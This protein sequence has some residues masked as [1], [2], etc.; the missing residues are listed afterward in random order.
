MNATIGTDEAARGTVARRRA[1]RCQAAR[2]QAA[3]FQATSG[4]AARGRPGRGPAMRSAGALLT[5]L[6]LLAT[7]ATATMAATTMAATATRPSD[8]GQSAL[9]RARTTPVPLLLHVEAP[10]DSGRHLGDVVTYQA[11]LAWPPGWEI[12]R[13]GIPAPVPDNAPIELSSYSTRAAPDQCPTCRWLDLRWQVFKAV[14]M[15]EDLPLPAPEVRFR[16][17]AEIA[18]V[19]LPPTVVSVSPLVPWERRKDWIDSIRAG[20]GPVFLD[21]SRLWWQAALAAGLGLLALLGWGWA[22]GRWFL[23]R[24]ARP[25]ARAW[26]SVQGRHAADGAADQAQTEDLKDWHR[27]FDATA[28]E[29]VVPGRLDAFLAAHRHLAP[30]ADEIRA[31]FEA[32]QRHFFTEALAPV[33]RLPRATLIATLRRLADAEFRP[34]A[35]IGAP[36]PG[37]RGHAPV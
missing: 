12:D 13:D 1:A 29:T 23:G 32:S 3:R 6:M 24:Q 25:F 22:S 2:C 34:G 7:A 37:D 26:R 27:A 28:G 18:T 4:Q 11:L 36:T 8:D 16:R 31:V 17:E 15:T 20:W 30:Y 5:V 35:G 10:R 14:R 19:A 9:D 21:A 33:A